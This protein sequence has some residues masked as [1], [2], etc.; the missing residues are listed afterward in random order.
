MDQREGAIAK[1]PI[2]LCKCHLHCV[3]V[4]TQAK[5]TRLLQKTPHDATPPLATHEPP[6]VALLRLAVQFF[7]H[8]LVGLCALLTTDVQGVVVTH[9]RTV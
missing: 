8:V 7:A 9:G 1:V 6:D 2:T 3:G 4:E 5:H